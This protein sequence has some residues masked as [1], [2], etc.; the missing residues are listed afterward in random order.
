ML[1]LSNTKEQAGQQIIM[2]N[3]LRVKDPKQHLN[4]FIQT[5]WAI[6]NTGC[7]F[8]LIV[9]EQGLFILVNWL[10]GGLDLMAPEQGMSL[11]HN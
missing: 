7:A 5:L 6:Q 4:P 2:S 9:L 3:K 10:V 8:K 11:I 1:I